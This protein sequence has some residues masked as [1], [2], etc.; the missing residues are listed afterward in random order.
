[1]K[2]MRSLRSHLLLTLAALFPALTS[3]GGS[4]SEP[5]TEAQ[6]LEFHWIPK[7]LNNGVFET[8]HEGAL[9]KAHELSALHG[10]RVEIHYTATDSAADVAGQAELVRR[11]AEEGA[12][13]VAI[14][15][16]SPDELKDAIDEVVAAGIPV[17]TFDSDSPESERFTYLGVDNEQGGMIAA[18]ILGEAMRESQKKRVAL[19]SG[20]RGATN[21]E[22]RAKGFRDTLASE[23]PELE[24]ADTVYCDDDAELSASLVEGLMR[25]EPNLGGL[26]FVG[27]WP[28]FMCDGT[29]CGEKMPK[30]NAAAR[31]GEVRTVAFDTLDFELPFV[32]EGMVAGLIGQK[33][34]GWGFDAVQM[35]YD[36]VVD[37]QSFAAWTDSGTDVVCPN[38]VA[39]MS[40]AW[41]NLN[42]KGEL[43]ACEVNGKLISKER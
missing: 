40:A 23:Y 11:A 8:G 20:V 30:W 38:N 1:M 7:E 35:L 10:R 12:N 21:L 27:L 32:E 5:G 42:F 26:F 39:E 13:G 16:N 17:L 9:A 29:D 34:W 36:R 15:C 3:C 31:A 18:R 41:G 24:L 33:Y 25:D 22:A 6:P 28:L 4:A 37:D 43:M 19:V 2:R 14:S